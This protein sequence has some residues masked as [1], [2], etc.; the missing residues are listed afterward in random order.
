MD[1]VIASEPVRLRDGLERLLRREGPPGVATPARR[2]LASMLAARS[3]LN[4]ST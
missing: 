1:L 2:A 4:I 3:K